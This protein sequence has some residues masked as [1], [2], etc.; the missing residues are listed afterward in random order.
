MAFSEISLKELHKELKGSYPEKIELLPA[1]GSDRS[2]FRIFS[3][4]GK[5]CI[6]TWNEEVK[7]NEAFIYFSDHFNKCMLPVPEVLIVDKNKKTYLQSDLGDDTLFSVLS[8]NGLSDEVVFHY[9]NVVRWLPAFQVRGIKGLDL[10]YCYPRQH[11]DRQSMMWDLNYFK[12]YFARLSGIKFDEQALEDDFLTLVDF[13][14][15]ANRN[16]FMFRDFQSRNIMILN[17][18]PYFIDYQG[19]RSGALQYDLASLLYD[20]KA[21]LPPAF[22]NELIEEY[23]KALA[24]E[25]NKEINRDDFLKYFNGFAL[26]RILQALGAYGFR[27]FY[28]KKEHF[29]QSI[30]Y[31]MKNL[32]QLFGNNDFIVKLPE[33]SK[34]PDYGSNAVVLREIPKTDLKV[35]ITSFS[36]KHGIPNDTTGNGGGFVFD[37]RA[38]PNPGRLVDYQTQSGLDEPVIIYLKAFPEIN[39]FLENVFNIVDAAVKNYIDRGFKNLMVSFGCTGGRH[40]SVYCAE[41][42]AEH[43]QQKFGIITIPEHTRKSNWD[44]D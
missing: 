13:L 43:L 17:N 22:R 2:Y 10:S 41:K 5:S 11:F 31:A 21:N 44:S 3:D 32:R 1:S 28:Q 19:G 6:G 29:L 38:L 24:V 14:L 8:S 18:K 25:T 12:Y 15:T 9:M 35:R 7:E 36:Y 37:C 42:L 33:L 30:P 4:D 27:G 26:L 23:L 40:R 20:A 34:L 39:S 16:Y